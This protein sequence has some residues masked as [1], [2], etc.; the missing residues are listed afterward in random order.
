M[1]TIFNFSD[2]KE[3]DYIVVLAPRDDN[4][5]CW[6]H[7]PKCK[8]KV[9]VARVQH[10]VELNKEKGVYGLYGWFMWNGPRTLTQSMIQRPNV[11]SIEFPAESLVGVFE[12][13]DDFSLNSS[14]I[15]EIKRHIRAH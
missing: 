15:A 14:N 4:D 2:I 12:Y 9:W 10:L 7:M 5:P 13:E 11:E 1:A 3:N 6:F 8:E